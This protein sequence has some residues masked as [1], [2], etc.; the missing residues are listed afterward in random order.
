MKSN[1][2]AFPHRA[3]RTFVTN[4]SMQ[5]LPQKEKMIIIM[6]FNLKTLPQRAERIFATKSNMQTLP[7]RATKILFMKS[8]KQ[9]HSRK[10][11][12]SGMNY[13]RIIHMH[14]IMMFIKELQ[15]IK[16]TNNSTI[17]IFEVKNVLGSGKEWAFQLLQFVCL[18][19]ELGNMR[20]GPS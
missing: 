18:M 7:H 5:T 13:S 6:K 11:S 8:S 4:S 3:T 16:L 10:T 17:I 12:L 19:R 15:I 2:Q 20:Y 1:I 14:I 9:E